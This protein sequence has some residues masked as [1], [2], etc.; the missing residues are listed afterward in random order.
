MLLEA[1]AGIFSALGLTLT[2]V[3]GLSHNGRSQ[4]VSATV[5][6][7]VGL[8]LFFQYFCSR[9]NLKLVQFYR[10]TSVR[11]QEQ[12]RLA[13]LA[14]VLLLVAIYG[15]GIWSI[16]ATGTM[17]VEDAEFDASIAWRYI[18]VG[19][20]E[21]LLFY[22]VATEAKSGRGVLIVTVVAALLQVIGLAIVANGFSQDNPL[23]PAWFL[24]VQV[25]A[26]TWATV[27]DFAIYNGLFCGACAM[28][29]GRFVGCDGQGEDKTTMLDD[30]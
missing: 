10:D 20:I 19:Y 18:Q 21:T 30:F 23:F 5:F 16:D 28:H 8:I 25:L 14:V 26:T 13:G 4:A 7:V 11:A 6:I 12:Q 9:R 27:Y 29:R 2:F 17:A 3:F 22:L 15:T 1:F 24:V